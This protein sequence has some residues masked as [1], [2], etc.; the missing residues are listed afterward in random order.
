MGGP[1]SSRLSTP[2]APDSMSSR[3]DRHP[4]VH[5]AIVRDQLIVSSS[6]ATLGASF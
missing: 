5:A 6:A 1:P 4:D 2:V 3:V